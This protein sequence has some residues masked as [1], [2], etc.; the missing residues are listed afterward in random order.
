MSATETLSELSNIEESSLTLP[1][2]TEEE[3]DSETRSE[4]PKDE[5]KP[6]SENDMKNEDEAQDN[7]KDED[8]KDEDDDDDNDEDSNDDDDDDDVE[9][10]PKSETKQNKKIMIL[11]DQEDQVSAGKLNDEDEDEFDELDEESMATFLKNILNKE[12]A[13]RYLGSQSDKPETGNLYDDAEGVE[14]LTLSDFRKSPT[15]KLI[16]VHPNFKNKF[17]LLMAYAPWCP[18]CRSPDTIEL[19]T[20]LA[21]IM[22]GRF[23][24]GAINCTNTNAKNDVLAKALKVQG[25]PSI[26]LIRKDRKIHP[27]H[28]N[29]SVKDLLHFVCDKVK[30]FC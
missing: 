28:G 25:Y 26:F 13:N 10:K 7:D 3:R 16:L 15:K 12:M 1:T 23:Q 18:H 6:Q 20:K 11:G 8:D 5:S 9:D 19:W 4:S 29:R 27:Y 30:Q 17:G 24:L 2:V 22:K 14:E 21:K